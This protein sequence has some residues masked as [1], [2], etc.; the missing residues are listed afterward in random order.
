VKS[1]RRDDPF[2]VERSGPWRRRSAVRAGRSY[3][4]KEGDAGPEQT[5]RLCCVYVEPRARRQS[6]FSSGRADLLAEGSDQL[7]ADELR[8]GRA[9]C[10]Y[11]RTRHSLSHLEGVFAPVLGC[12]RWLCRKELAS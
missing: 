3:A 5:A 7:R 11:L 12:Y 1:G 9:E 6:Q 10:N 2:V 4:D 8:P